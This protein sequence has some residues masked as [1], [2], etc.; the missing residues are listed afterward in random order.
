MKSAL[1]RG[2]L[3]GLLGAVLCLGSV[4]TAFGPAATASSSLSLPPS[5]PKWSLQKEF[6][7]FVETLSAVACANSTDC[8]VVGTSASGAATAARSADGGQDWKTVVLPANA[9]YLDAAACPTSSE[10]VVVGDNH[11][12]AAGVYVTSDG[13]ARWTD[14]TVPDHLGLMQGVACSDSSHCW[15]VGYSDAG[16]ASVIATTNGGTT[17]SSEPLPSGIGLLQAVSCPTAS[18]CT[19]V[20]QKSGGAGTVLITS[21]GGTVW[22]EQAVSAGLA[23]LESVTCPTVHVCAAAGATSSG[24]GAVLETRD[25]GS[26]WASEQL[27]SGAESFAGV[28]CPTAGDCWAVGS[29]PYGGAEIVATTT[30]GKTWSSQTPAGGLNSLTAVA[31][32]SVQDCWALGTTSDSNE[33]L[34]SISATSDEGASWAVQPLPATIFNL[35]AVSCPTASDCVSVGSTTLGSGAIV[36]S[37]DGGGLWV[38]SELPTGQQNLTLTAIACATASDCWAVGYTSTGSSGFVSEHGVIL[39]TTDGG[40]NWKLERLPPGVWSLAGISCPSAA[41]CVAVGQTDTGQSEALMTANGGGSWSS[42]AMSLPDTVQQLDGVSCPSATTCWAVGVGTSNQAAIVSTGDGGQKWTLDPSPEGISGFSGLSG[43]SCPTTSICYAAG[44]Q[45][46]APKG[47]PEILHVLAA[48]TDAGHTWKIQQLPT[49]MGYLF[50]VSC[51]SALDCWATGTNAEVSGVV[52]TTAD[53]GQHWTAPALP[54]G[55][56][57]LNGVSCPSSGSCWSVGTATDGAPLVIAT[58]PPASGMRLTSTSGGVPK[59]FVANS[60]T[61]VG[62]QDAWVLGEA[63]CSGS[64]CSYVVDTTNAGLRWQLDGSVPSPIAGQQQSSGVTEVRF[65]TQKVGYAFGPGLLRTSD[66]GQTWTAMAIP[67]GGAQ[68]VSLAADQDAAYALVS[69]CPYKTGICDKPFRLFR[70]S[71]A[72]NAWTSVMHVASSLSG[73]VAVFGETAYVISSTAQLN[74]APDQFFA[75]TDGV[76]FVARPDPCDTSHEVSLVQ[77]VPTS[78]SDVSLLCLGNPNQEAAVKMVYRST[79]TGTTDTS[80]GTL[81]P[82]GGTAQLA[83]ST[84]GH[85]AVASASGDS[86]MY[87]D[88]GGG[89]TWTLTVNKQDGGLGW[90]DVVYSSARDVWVVYAPAQGFVRAG[91]LWKSADGGR[92]WVVVNP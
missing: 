48:T 75:S 90:N 33:T 61:W 34:G 77:V 71:T 2:P 13:G 1:M 38:E 19:A 7:G 17:W 49:G 27:P 57:S 35:T 62:S 91:Q 59:G 15:A 29:T 30:G 54:T 60:I 31:C 87:I 39:A 80:A 11:S 72:S 32:P 45:V 76:H 82:G 56:V 21:D 66:G 44:F 74:P 20:G 64:T 51:P 83:V 70:R 36:S 65:A 24:V 78:V 6:P 69:P 46:V 12:D 5:S 58:V 79:D 22:N 16:A 28:S 53:G 68:V 41:E 43:V 10:C 81:P 25:G 4:G 18:N 14:G 89:Q 42:R 67:G 73:D 8:L 9:G 23:G 40:A 37:D 52:Y 50:G 92:H 3:A 47:A 84:N 86:L 26:T 88:D 85:M 63:P 55:T